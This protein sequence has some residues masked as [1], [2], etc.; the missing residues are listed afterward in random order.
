MASTD[1]DI[2]IDREIVDLEVK[3]ALVIFKTVW[4]E[5]EEEF[6]REN[7]RFPKEFILLGGAP[8]SG[9]GTHTTFIMNIRGLTCP[10]IVVSD[11]LV[12]PEALAIKA[13]GKM[14]GDKEVIGILCRKLLQEEFRDGALLDGF[15]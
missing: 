7:L 3:D 11:L 5:L 10:S 6:G 4:E 9:K 12:T 13:Q 15:P 8:G 2:S 14:V 1:R